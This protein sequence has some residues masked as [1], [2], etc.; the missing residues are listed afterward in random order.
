MHLCKNIFGL[1]VKNNSTA[2]GFSGTL[3]QADS[4]IRSSRLC[5]WQNF[6]IDSLIDSEL[7]PPRSQIFSYCEDSESVYLLFLFRDLDMKI[8]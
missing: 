6:D 8:L 7:K 4:L 3:K 1:F 5:N 2:A